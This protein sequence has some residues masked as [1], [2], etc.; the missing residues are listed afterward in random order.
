MLPP[1]SVEH[2]AW[3]EPLFLAVRPHGKVYAKACQAVRLAEYGV[4]S[5][6]CA[7]THAIELNPLNHLNR[8]G[9]DHID[10]R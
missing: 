10:A 9:S 5:A 2:A 1:S 6:K 8:Q 7:A 3:G 4:P